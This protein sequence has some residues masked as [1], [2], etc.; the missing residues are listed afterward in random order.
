MRWWNSSALSRNPNRREPFGDITIAFNQSPDPFLSKTRVFL[1]SSGFVWSLR[2]PGQLR[3]G[4][5]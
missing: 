1:C 4:V 5:S 3:Y 2:T